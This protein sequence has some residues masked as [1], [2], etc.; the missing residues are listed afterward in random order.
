[1][2]SLH[3][4][5]LV[6]SR[7]KGKSMPSWPMN[8]FGLFLYRT[9]VRLYSGCTR[10]PTAQIEAA[11]GS[12]RSSGYVYFFSLHNLMLA[13]HAGQEATRSCTKPRKKSGRP[14]RC[15]RAGGQVLPMGGRL[16]KGTASCRWHGNF[17]FGPPRLLH[18]S[19]TQGDVRRQE[20]E[21]VHLTHTTCFIIVCCR[22]HSV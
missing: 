21:P 16:Q 17:P 12:T 13:L 6:G 1:M 18:F 15:T 8:T 5:F 4:L 22:V 10:A 2:G 3:D 9:A 11:F 19:A 7:W 14:L 20:V